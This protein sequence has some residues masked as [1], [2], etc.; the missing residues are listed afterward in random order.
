MSQQIADKF[1][2]ALHKLEESRDLETIVKL[3]AEDAEI[4]NV[5]AP[6]KFNGRDGAREFWTK[7]RD[8]FGEVYSTFRNIINTDNHLALEWTTEG[9]TS[10]GAPVKYEG[11]SILEI[12]A[13][14]VTRFR[15]YFDAGDLGR[16]VAKE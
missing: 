12:E 11:V 4:G 9:T 6:E 7:Y 13:G 14:A 10:G 2:E 5:V 15:A 1:I 16:Q 8:T 3:F